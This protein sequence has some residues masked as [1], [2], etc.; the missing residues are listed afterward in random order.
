MEEK[1]TILLVDDDVDY[2]FQQQLMLE[3]AGY[4]VIAA[5]SQKEAESILQK[6]KPDL[7]LLDLMMENEDSGFILSYKIKRKYPEVPVIISTAVT[8]ETG[9]N[10]GLNSAEEKSWIKADVYVEKG[11][12]PELLKV[13]IKKL[14]GK[15]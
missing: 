11:I 9:M 8:T 10:F 1:K 3:K 13:E 2:L 14:I 6:V 5:D 4:E 12:D 15:K 7:A